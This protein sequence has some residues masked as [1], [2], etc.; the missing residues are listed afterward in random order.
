MQLPKLGTIYDHRVIGESKFFRVL[1]VF[2]QLPGCFKHIIDSMNQ[3]EDQFASVHYLPV[4]THEKFEK[5]RDFASLKHEIAHGLGFH[6]EGNN[7]P[8]CKNCNEGK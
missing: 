2:T 8:Y 5:K 3:S 4:K 1:S 7:H 6:D